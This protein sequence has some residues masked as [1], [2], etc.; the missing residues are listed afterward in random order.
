ML[1]FFPSLGWLEAAPLGNTSTAQVIPQGIPRGR[2]AYH[3]SNRLESLGPWPARPHVLGLAP[4]PCL[5]PHSLPRRCKT[6][7]A[8][9]ILTGA[10]AC[11]LSYFGLPYHVLSS[12]SHH[13]VEWYSTLPPVSGF[14]SRALAGVRSLF[15]KCAGDLTA[16]GSIYRASR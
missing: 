3:M 14:G 6:T 1:A 11:L 12:S 9:L 16:F 5:V 13:L 2:F 15:R 7:L 8:R 4:S 10:C